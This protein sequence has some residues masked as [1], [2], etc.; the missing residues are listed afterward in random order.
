[1]TSLGFEMMTDETTKDYELL[2][3]DGEH[4]ASITVHKSVLQVCSPFFARNMTCFF[5]TWQIPENCTIA[6][7]I[8]L[9]KF[10]YTRN[11]NDIID[12]NQSIIMCNQLECPLIQ[13]ELVDGQQSRRITL[14][15]KL[16]D[17]SDNEEEVHEKTSEATVENTRDNTSETTL[18]NI[19]V[20][21]PS[22]P[23]TRSYLRRRVST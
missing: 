18:E 2:V 17:A 20:E 6:S 12:Y 8:R 9:I 15:R 7:A 22:R 10:F 19:H 23:M 21:P 14:K 4:L 11:H 5:Y 13:K 1:M 3:Y 16:M